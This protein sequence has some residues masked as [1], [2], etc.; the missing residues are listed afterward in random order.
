LVERRRERQ[1]EKGEKVVFKV[2]DNVW[3]LIEA[4]KKTLAADVRSLLLWILDELH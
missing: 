1:R 3:R 2:K 4:E